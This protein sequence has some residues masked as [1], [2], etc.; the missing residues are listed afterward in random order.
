M[1]NKQFPSKF[2]IA[3]YQNFSTAL[4]KEIC[5]RYQDLKGSLFWYR[6]QV[7]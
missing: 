2:L 7:T 1:I 5:P 6:T 3:S 4:T